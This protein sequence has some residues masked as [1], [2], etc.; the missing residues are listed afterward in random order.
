MDGSWGEVCPQ[1][2]KLQ[3]K[4]PRQERQ[5]DVRLQ[6]GAEPF[7]QHNCL[8]I[9]PPDPED[10]HSSA[11]LI[12]TLTFDTLE[13]LLWVGSCSVGGIS[14]T[15][16]SVLSCFLSSPKSDY[17]KGCLSSYY[18][19]ELQRYTALR[20][21]APHEGAISQ[22]LVHERGIFSVASRSLHHCNRRGLTKWHTS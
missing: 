21:H 4:Y 8:Q 1:F 5:R 7:V 6:K 16:R 11:H 18:G 14:P 12:S 17:V 13:D 3:Q 9:P 10:L 2:S 20:A 22:I 15:C 19:T